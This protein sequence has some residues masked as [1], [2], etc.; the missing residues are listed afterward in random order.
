MS[1]SRTEQAATAITRELARR[2]V[3]TD[4]STGLIQIT[5]TVKF[6]AE[7]GTFRG[8]VWNDEC[9]AGRRASDLRVLSDQDRR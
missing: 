1:V 5:I 2:K 3:L 8:L 6:A 4:S 9:V 7:T